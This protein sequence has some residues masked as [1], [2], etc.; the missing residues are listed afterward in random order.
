M[1]VEE[2]LLLEEKMK[3]NN[4]IVNEKDWDQIKI[5]RAHV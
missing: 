1:T 3:N 5:G 4:S 2:K